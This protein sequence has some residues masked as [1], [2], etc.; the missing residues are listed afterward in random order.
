MIHLDVHI[1]GDNCWPDLVNEHG[2]PNFI[3]GQ[4]TGIARLPGGTASGKSSV[5]VRI[6]LPDGRVVLAQTT[7]DLLVNAVMAFRVAETGQ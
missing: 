6:E 7:L 5:T 1:D 3:S 4:W 2:Q